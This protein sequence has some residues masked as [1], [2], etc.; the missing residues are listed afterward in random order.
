MERGWHAMMC[1]PVVMCSPSVV[2][3][4][5]PLIPLDGLLDAQQHGSLP[6]VQ[7]RDG[8]KLFNLREGIR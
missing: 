4:Q 2:S 8:I 7:T 3:L 1:A 5:V 6:L